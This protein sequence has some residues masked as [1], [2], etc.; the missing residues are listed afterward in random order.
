MGG[1]D[2][3]PV[4][5]VAQRR[6][7]VENENAVQLQIEENHVDVRGAG[8]Q[9]IGRAVGHDNPDPLRGIGGG[10]GPDPVDDDLMVVDHGDTDG[11]WL[12]RV[13]THI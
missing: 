4:A 2:H 3:H 9:G 7:P 1:E 12:H 11:A 5:R 6:D 10:P 13:S 8:Q